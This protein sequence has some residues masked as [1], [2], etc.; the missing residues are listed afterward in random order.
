M[1]K[2]TLMA[3]K[4]FGESYYDLLDRSIKNLIKLFDINFEVLKIRIKILEQ[5]T[6][7]EDNNQG[8]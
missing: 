6:R 1:S 8:G 4:K 5:R 2:D 7:N 3:P